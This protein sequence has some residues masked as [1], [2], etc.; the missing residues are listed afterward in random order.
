MDG[1]AKKSQTRFVGIIMSLNIPTLSFL[2]SYHVPADSD[3][4]VLSL[5]KRNSCF[6]LYIAIIMAR[7]GGG[8]TI[9]LLPG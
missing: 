5:T 1:R 2:I 6:S 7:T 8:M 4:L 3:S 9:T